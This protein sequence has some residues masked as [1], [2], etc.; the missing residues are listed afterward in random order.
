MISTRLF[1]GIT[2]NQ[3]LDS[4]LG[5]LVHNGIHIITR[6]EPGLRIETS[7]TVFEGTTEEVEAEITRLGLTEF[8]EDYN[9]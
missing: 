3:S 8:Q 7:S 6:F 5:G 1:N 4:E 9:G 2:I